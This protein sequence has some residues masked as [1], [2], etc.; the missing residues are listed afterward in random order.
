MTGNR[1]TVG[2]C[3]SGWRKTLYSDA[4]M[5][6]C[7]LPHAGSRRSLLLSLS[8]VQ[9]KVGMQRRVY[10][11]GQVKNSLTSGIIFRL[12]GYQL[13]SAASPDSP[14]AASLCRTSAHGC[15]LLGGLRALTRCDLNCTGVLLTLQKNTFRPPRRCSRD[16]ASLL[17]LHCFGHGPAI[18]AWRNIAHDRLMRLERC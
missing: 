15:R 4:L 7:R 1:R 2:T 10:P 13:S 14:I 8:S 3:R 11:D 12:S 6:Y 18:S 17:P 9:V 5:S 16:N